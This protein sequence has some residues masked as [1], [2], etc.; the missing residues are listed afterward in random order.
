MSDVKAFFSCP[1]AIW[2]RRSMEMVSSYEDLIPY[3]I[4][5]MDINALHSELMMWFAGLFSDFLFNGFNFNKT[6]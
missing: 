4:D 5:G 2:I 3:Q 1:S 6:V